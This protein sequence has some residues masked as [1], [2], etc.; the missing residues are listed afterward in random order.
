M[1]VRVLFLLACH[2]MA[3]MQHCGVRDPMQPRSRLLIKLLG[4]ELHASLLEM[5]VTRQ[6]TSTSACN[7]EIVGFQGCIY[8]YGA[9]IHAK[10]QCGY[11]YPSLTSPALLF[12]L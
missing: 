8:S 1:Q 5:D 6:K 12:G 3:V 10:A 7:V 11:N 2:A 4:L 9:C